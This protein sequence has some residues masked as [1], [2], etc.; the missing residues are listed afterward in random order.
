M[1][2]TRLLILGALRFMQPTHGYNVRRELESWHADQWANIAYGSIYHAL[3]TMADE[4]LIRPVE[5]EQVGGRPARTSY[6]VTDQGEEEFQRLLRE[7]W[8]ELKPSTDPFMVAL[9]FNSDLP[10]DEIIAA[11]R[12]RIAMVNGQIEEL[13]YNMKSPLSDYRPRHVA[14]QLRLAIMRLEAE[15]RWAEEAIPKVERDELP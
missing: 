13:E 7:Y 6:V 10:K 2:A 9:A 5:T 15:L 3:K 14:D 1:S 12:H 11:L 8:W 4:G